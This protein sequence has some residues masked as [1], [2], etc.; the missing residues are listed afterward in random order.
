MN[1]HAAFLLQANAT[2]PDRLDKFHNWRKFY[3]LICMPLE[4]T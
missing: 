3:L 4:R 1:E 2:D